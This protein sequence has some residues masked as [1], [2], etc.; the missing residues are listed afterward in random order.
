[1]FF[2]APMALLRTAWA[3]PF[4]TLL[5]IVLAK[6]MANRYGSMRDIPGPILAR[7]T[8]LYKV[9]HVI[10]GDWHTLNIQLHDQYGVL[11]RIAPNECSVADPNATKIIYG[12]A[13]RFRKSQWYAAWF[14]NGIP[15]LFSTQDIT[16]HSKTKRKYAHVYTLS[17]VLEMQTNVDKV[18]ALLIQRVDE[19]AQNN[20]TFD[21]CPWLQMYAFDVI[22]EVSYGK[23]FGLLEGTMSPQILVAVQAMNDNL[24]FVFSTL[25]PQNIN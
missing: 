5:V 25:T 14:R 9:Y 8:Q 19:F 1:M 20:I 11:V 2:E 10:K 21:L 6:V 12:H 24:A 3:H 15:G 13:T 4:L 18:T 7:Y 16:W 23:A 17:N 22:G